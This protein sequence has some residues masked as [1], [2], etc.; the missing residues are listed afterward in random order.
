MPIPMILGPLAITFIGT[1]VATARADESSTREMISKIVDVTHRKSA[2]DQ[3]C[4]AVAE[5]I[6]GQ[7]NTK[8]PDAN[9]EID[10]RS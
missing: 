4:E 10:Q 1:V 3:V 7:V 9:K 2:V 8:H 5:Q 6:I